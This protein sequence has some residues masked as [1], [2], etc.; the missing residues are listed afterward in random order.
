MILSKTFF[1][2]FDITADESVCITFNSEI[3]LQFFKLIRD[4]FCFGMQ[5]ITPCF[6]VILN[7]PFDTHNLKTVR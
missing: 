4:L 1:N 2:H 5:V 7:E 3:G 6:F